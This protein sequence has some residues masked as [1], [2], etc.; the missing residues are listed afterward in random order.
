[1]ALILRALERL[2]FPVACKLECAEIIQPRNGA[3]ACA[4]LNTSGN[5]IGMLAPLVTPFI[6]QRFGWTSA[7][8][9]ACVV[10]AAG[11]LLWLGIGRP[12]ERPPLASDPTTGPTAAERPGG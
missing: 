2:D 6:G 7:I 9:V 5:G 8:F 1:M 10:C 11:G 3:L 12:A 4:L